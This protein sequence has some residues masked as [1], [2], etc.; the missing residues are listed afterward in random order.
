MNADFV[1]VKV[2]R[3]ERPD[4]DAVYMRATTALTGHG[5]WPMTVFLTP[6]GRPFY[7]GTYFPPQP[8]MGMPSFQQLLAAIAEAWKERRAEVLTAGQRITEG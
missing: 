6:E 4:V 8:R 7:A 5:G 1:C 3:E 2:D